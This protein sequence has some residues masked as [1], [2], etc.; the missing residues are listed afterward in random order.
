MLRALIVSAVAA[1]VTSTLIQI[2]LWWGFTDASPWPLLSRDARLTAAIVMG[3]TVL[4]PSGGLDPMVWL[5]AAFIHSMLSIIYAAIVVY[6]ASRFGIVVS[7][8]IGT[9]AGVMI[10]IVNLYGFTAIFPWFA[11]SRGGITLLAH[12]VFGMTLAGTYTMLRE[13]RRRPVRRS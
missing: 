6:P 9:A 2:L 8:I 12:V 11:Q 3:Q 7:M 5:V 1:A 13:N 10:Y 4:P